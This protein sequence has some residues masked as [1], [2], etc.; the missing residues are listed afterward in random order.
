MPV[1]AQVQ[2]SCKVDSA[3]TML[4]ETTPGNNITTIPASGLQAQATVLYTCDAGTDFAIGLGHIGTRNMVNGANTLAYD[5]SFSNANTNG[6]PATPAVDVAVGS[7]T[8]HAAPAAVG[9]IYSG[10]APNGQGTLTVFGFIAGTTTKPVPGFYN[11]S[12]P[13]NIVY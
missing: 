1:Q 10:T 5:L 4:F 8:T 9:A 3:S 11:D 2:S 13:V 6:V 7:T 12:V